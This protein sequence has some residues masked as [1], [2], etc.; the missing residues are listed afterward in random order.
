MFQFVR[1]I[2]R[3]APHKPTATENIDKK[4]QRYRKIWY[5]KRRQEPQQGLQVFLVIS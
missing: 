4:Y 5:L 2:Y 1:M 3:P